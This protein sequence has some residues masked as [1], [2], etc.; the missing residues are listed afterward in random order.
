MTRESE[1]EERQ[2]Y[3]ENWA[4]ICADDQPECGKDFCDECGD[5]LECYGGEGGPCVHSIA[6]HVWIR[7]EKTEDT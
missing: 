6:G 7:R 5:C 3:R 4:R 1:A 2:R